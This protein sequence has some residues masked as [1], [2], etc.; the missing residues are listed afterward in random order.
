MENVGQQKGKGE[1]E[2]D[3][4]YLCIRAREKKNE[5]WEGESSDEFSAP[6]EK[7]GSNNT[8]RLITKPMW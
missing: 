5:T 8:H 1:L 4:S 7:G 2:T 6:N 3:S